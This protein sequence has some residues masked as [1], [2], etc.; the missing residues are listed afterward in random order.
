MTATGLS[1]DPQ[2]YRT[3]LDE[4]SEEQIDSWSVELL[5]DMSIRKGVLPVLAEFGHACR[6]DDTGILRAFSAGGGAPATAGRTADGRLMLPAVSLRYLVPGL[7][8]ET[9][10]AR[11]RLIDYLVASFDELVYI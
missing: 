9:R 3:R 8:A 4:Q 10:D 6:L 5:R 11:T 7:R 1:A 2:E